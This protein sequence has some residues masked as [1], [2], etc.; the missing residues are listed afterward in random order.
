MNY[1]AKRCWTF[2]EFSLFTRLVR[3]TKQLH[4]R[5]IRSFPLFPTHFAANLEKMPVC[6]V[7]VACS[8]YRNRRSQPDRASQKI[9][10][11][12]DIWQAIHLYIC[13]CW[14]SFVGRVVIS[15]KIFLCAQAYQLACIF[16]W[17]SRESDNSS[18]GSTMTRHFDSYAHRCLGIKSS[19]GTT[20]NTWSFFVAVVLTETPRYLSG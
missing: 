11:F 8:R 5:S 12:C 17:K 9:M 3:L 2:G 1:V 13:Y 7:R 20:R 14:L 10:T 16:E 6:T 15:R 18:F 4:I 19:S